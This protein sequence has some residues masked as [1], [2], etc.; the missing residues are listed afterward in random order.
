MWKKCL[1]YGLSASNRSPIS[2]QGVRMKLR[3]GG[4]LLTLSAPRNRYSVVNICFIQGWSWFVLT[5]ASW[6]DE[7]L[8][9]ILH[10]Q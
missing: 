9:C 7:H 5:R 10:S 8:D 6:Q 2:L 4:F 3:V 1:R